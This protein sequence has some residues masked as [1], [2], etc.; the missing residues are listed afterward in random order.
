MLKNTQKI[1]ICDKNY[2]DG[3][4]L[5]LVSIITVMINCD[6]EI[7]VLLYK[8]AGHHIKKIFYA[9]IHQM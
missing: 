2:A 1:I 7:M 3:L 9:Q 5:T 8:T 6:I 4:S